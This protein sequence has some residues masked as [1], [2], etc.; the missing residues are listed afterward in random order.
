[1]RGAADPVTRRAEHGNLDRGRAMRGLFAASGSSGA[2]Q[3][4]RTG[5]M[6]NKSS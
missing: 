3:I 6:G 4:V 1:M 5:G 2:A